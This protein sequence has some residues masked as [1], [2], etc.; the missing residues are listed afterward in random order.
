MQEIAN[1][2]GT[3]IIC[4]DGKWNFFARYQGWYVLG[5][6]VYD[7]SLDKF[8]KAIVTVLEEKN[9]KFDLPKDERYAAQIYGKKTKY[10]MQ[11]HKG[12]AESL[13]LL[14]TQKNTLIHCSFNKPEQ[15]AILSVRDIF[16]D[17][18]WVTW[19]SLGDELPFLAEAAPSEFLDAIESGL[20]AIPCPFDELF[21]Q[22][23]S[24]IFGA[25]YT[26]GLLWS[27]EM[28]AWDSDLFVRTISIF[29]DLAARDP[30]GNWGNRPSNSLTAIFLPWLPQTCAPIKK[31][32]VA[33]NIIL[34]EHPDVAWKLLISLL[35]NSHKVSDFTRRPVWRDTIPDNW[36][37]G[38]TRAEMYNQSIEYAQIAFNAAKTNVSWLVELVQRLVNIPQ[39]VRDQL[40]SFLVSDDILTLPESDRCQLWTALVNLVVE[41]RKYSDADWTLKSHQIDEVESIARKLTPN[42]PQFLFKRLF[43]KSDLEL[44]REKQ[45]FDEQRGLLEEERRGAVGKIFNEVGVQGVIDFAFSVQSPWKVGYALGFFENVNLDNSIIPEMLES[46]NDATEQFVNGF[47]CGRFQSNGWP[48]IDTLVMEK[49]TNGQIA[50]FFAQ[51]PFEQK[52][53]ERASNILGREESLYWSIAN[54]YPNHASEDTIGFAIDRLIKFGRP[55]AA[56]DCLFIVFNSTKKLDTGRAITALFALVNSPEILTRMDYY[57]IIEIIKKLQDDPQTDQEALFMVEWAY[58]PFIDMEEG[59]HPILIEKRL[60]N[61]PEL[62]CEV[63]RLIYPHKN[64]GRQ[65]E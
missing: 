33:I 64:E 22:E 45:N 44:Y 59:I 26:S 49:W 18:D 19:A 17:A 3:P 62:F 27:L 35:P 34:Q 54:A 14:S 7:K 12:L 65:S 21:A 29:G 15:V 9:P 55:G 53:W 10:S 51:L 46:V 58:L 32:S 8:R 40:L 36:T 11:I 28:L 52:T 23:S 1:R 42:S 4:Q 31:R 5:P 16:K 61:D 25:T 13:A 2:C 39:P 43:V 50:K 48:W 60:V 37:M 38:V 57:E 20:R 41:H 63:I 56:I 6:Y 24:G 47:I 30:G